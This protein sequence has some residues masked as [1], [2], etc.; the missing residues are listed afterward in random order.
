[1]TPS[2]EEFDQ[3][4][5]RDKRRIH[6]DPQTGAVA[7]GGEETPV[8]QQAPAAS[9]QGGAAAPAGVPSVEV[10]QLRASLE[11]R[12]AD[13][14]RL[15]AEYANYRKRVD[16]DREVVRETAL[17]GVLSELLGILDDI[18]R[19]RDHGE[20]EGGFKQVAESLENT[21]YK[22]GLVKFGAEGDPFDP[23][24]H[25]A[26]THSYSDAVTEPTCVHI[27]QPGYALGERLIRPA[28][29]AVAEPTEE[30]TQSADAAPS[31]GS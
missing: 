16:R 11:E 24:I 5:V 7:P 28:R 12:T 31:D 13:L 26:L 14:Q 8:Q 1:V 4:V 21:L 23:A 29:V 17:A 9:P 18:G 19:A 10:S 20:L 3:P 27:M 15:Q 25:E 30:L 2:Y 22:L 6:I